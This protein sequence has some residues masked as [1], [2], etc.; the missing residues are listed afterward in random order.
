MNVF[1][2]QGA[3]KCA[4]ERA[5]IGWGQTDKH[6]CCLK[7]CQHTLRNTPFCKDKHSWSRY[8]CCTLISLLFCHCVTTAAS[9]L[10][11]NLSTA[12]Q[13]VRWPPTRDTQ[14]NHPLH[15]WPLL[16]CSPPPKRHPPSQQCHACLQSLPQGSPRHCRPPAATAQP[17]RYLPPLSPPPDLA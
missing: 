11:A 12:G 1:E 2:Q 8:R 3:C 14:P 17:P 13:R 9:G 5:T 16:P 6:M 10:P 15:H 4:C 7:H